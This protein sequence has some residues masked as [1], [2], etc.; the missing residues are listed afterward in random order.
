MGWRL[1]IDHMKKGSQSQN[2]SGGFFRDRI[3]AIVL[4]LVVVAFFSTL[5]LLIWQRSTKPMVGDYE[6]TIVDRWADY[7]ESS[8]GSQPRLVLIVEST[9]GKRFTVKVDPNI[10]QSARVGMR[11]RSRSGQVVLI[12]SQKNSIAK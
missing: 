2:I 11:I 4:G 8:E 1:G 5:I 9:D 12:E 7:S 10:Y 6:G 3:K